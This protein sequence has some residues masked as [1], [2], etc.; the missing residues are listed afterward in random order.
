MTTAA[1]KSTEDCDAKRADIVDYL[2]L[3]I[4]E[5]L[6]RDWL[7]RAFPIG[8]RTKHQFPQRRRPSCWTRP[9][10]WWSA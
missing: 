7:A 8:E 9:R 6:F 10:A 1:R 4:G 5:K 2:R 3:G